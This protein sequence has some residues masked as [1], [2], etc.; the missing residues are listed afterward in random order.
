MAKLSSRPL[1]PNPF[2][3]YRDPE[4]GKWL[5]VESVS[6]ET[7]YCSNLDSFSSGANSKR[8]ICPARKVFLSNQKVSV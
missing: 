5:V 2:H 6:S 8:E 3:T 1:R 7:H 4:T